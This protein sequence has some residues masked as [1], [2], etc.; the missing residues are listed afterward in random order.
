MNTLAL[1]PTI[2]IIRQEHQRL[3]AVIHAM[4]YFVRGIGKGDNPP[5]FKVFRAMLLYIADFP[6][7]MH[8]PK[9]DELF[10]LLQKRTG[11]VDDT[12]ADLVVQHAQGEALVRNLEHQLTRYELQGGAAADAF[13]KA[14]EDYAAFYFGHMRL[15]EEIILPATDQFLTSEDWDQADLAFAANEASADKASFDQLFSMIANITPAPI[16]LGAPVGNGAA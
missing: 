6:E 15:E 9:E 14:V 12:I 11:T 7:K 2:R 5:P 16:G 10:V 8:H 13:F 1:H 4:L 3:G